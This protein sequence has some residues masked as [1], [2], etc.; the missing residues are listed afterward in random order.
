MR[1]KSI[2]QFQWV[3]LAFLAASAI[4]MIVNWSEA[5]AQL[6][7]NPGVEQIGLDTMIT[8]TIVLSALSYA[9][10]LLLWWLAAWKRSEVAKWIITIFFVLFQVLGLLYGLAAVGF[11][12]NLTLLIAVVCLVL[13]AYAVWLLF[14]PDAIAW[15]KKQ[16]TAPPAV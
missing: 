4:G 14:Q 6:E 15:F 16:D 7:V 11:T 9:I 5:V 1:P 2:V 3:Y 13:N 12:P 10:S 8:F